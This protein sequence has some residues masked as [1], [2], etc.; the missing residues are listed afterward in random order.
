MEM[1]PIFGQDMAGTERFRAWARKCI[2]LRRA[3][4]VRDREQLAGVAVHRPGLIAWLGVTKSH[5]RRG[6][7]SVLVACRLGA[8]FG[9][10]AGTDALGPDGGGRATTFAADH[11]HP[12]AHAALPF[13]RALGF[14][15]TAEAPEQ[16]PDG[17]PRVV[18]ALAR[19]HEPTEPA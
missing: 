6:I 8:A 2:R 18:V 19:D 12:E 1:G 15:E 16:S 7:G 11:P 3:W 13:Y 10:A 4:G 14:R 5:R 17:T 9:A